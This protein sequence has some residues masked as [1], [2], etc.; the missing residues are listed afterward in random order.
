MPLCPAMMCK[1]TWFGTAAVRRA[2]ICSARARS[3]AQEVYITVASIS[4]LRFCGIVTHLRCGSA[5]RVPRL[6]QLRFLS[7]PT[8]LTFRVPGLENKLQVSYDTHDTDE[9]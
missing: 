9:R 7:T 2:C 3:N 6:V 4:V 5:S 8:C 1:V